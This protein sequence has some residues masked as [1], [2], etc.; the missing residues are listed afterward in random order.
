MKIIDI[1][2]LF[3]QYMKQFITENKGKLN[4]ADIENK[5][6]EL[7]EKFGKT[8]L[9]ALNGMTP[10]SYYSAMSADELV[11]TLKKHIEND[12][13]VSDFLCEAIV[14]A[15][16]EKQLVALLE[17]EADLELL[18]YAVNLL[19]DK[20]SD[21]GF[22]KYFEFITADGLEDE[23]KDLLCEMLCDNAEK[24]KEKTL[25]V[26]PKAR[27]NKLYLIEILINCKK[28]ERITKIL[29]DELNS[30]KQIGL[31]CQYVIKYGDEKLIDVLKKRAGEEGIRFADYR[32]IVNAV[33]ALGGTIEENRD[34]SQDGD[35]IK[36]K[37]KSASKYFG[38]G[39]IKK[40]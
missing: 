16:T 28:D 38:K 3:K 21:A 23:F 24:V 37:Q 39:N 29:S 20:S 6:G 15:D 19:N 9:K 12:I 7:Y 14:A 10:V 1:D 8:S 33:M 22:D 4:E 18:S 32:E 2:K 5:I 31:Y 27:S 34:F 30:T 13:D 36:L 25:K 40:Q 17:K 26:F 11:E 35:Y